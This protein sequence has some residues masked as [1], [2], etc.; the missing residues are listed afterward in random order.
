MGSGT[1]HRS[2]TVKRSVSALSALENLSEAEVQSV[3]IIIKDCHA[4][5]EVA[6]NGESS[7]CLLFI[8]FYFRG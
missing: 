2:Y 8:T 6:E 7:G 4:L 1:D 5:Q 3:K